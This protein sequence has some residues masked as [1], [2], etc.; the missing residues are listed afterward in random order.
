MQIFLLLFLS[1]LVKL[2]FDLIDLSLDLVAQL[3]LTFDVK[4]GIL[5]VGSTL[6][7]VLLMCWA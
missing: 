7:N 4:T 6:P 1:H 2:S 3:C 5:E